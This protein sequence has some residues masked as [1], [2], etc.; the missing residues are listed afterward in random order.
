MPIAIGL[1]PPSFLRKVTSLALEMVFLELSGILSVAAAL[2][3][4]ESTERSL[5]LASGVFLC[6]IVDTAKIVR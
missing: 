3:W 2:H 4:S 6:V 5:T 1:T